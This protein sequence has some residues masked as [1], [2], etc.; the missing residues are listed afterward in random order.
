MKKKPAAKPKAIVG[1]AV[2]LPVEKSFAEVL[3]LI[4][5]ARQRAY[6]S[7]NTTLIDLYWQVGEYISGKL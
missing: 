6:Q 2:R 7:V 4:E 5:S 3:H 1:K